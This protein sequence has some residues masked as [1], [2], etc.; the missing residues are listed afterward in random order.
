M[1]HH[2]FPKLY[3][4]S[5][6][7]LSEPEKMLF[8]DVLARKHHGLSP[9]P[10]GYTLEGFIVEECSS[11]LHEFLYELDVPSPSFLDRL[12][13]IVQLGTS[14]LAMHRANRGHY[15][16]KLDN[17][18]ICGLRKTDLWSTANA[19]ILVKLSDFDRSRPLWLPPSA[20]K[21]TDVM[22][23]AYELRA[24][25]VNEDESWTPFGHAADA[26]SFVMTSLQILTLDDRYFDWI[27]ENGYWFTRN[28]NW[29]LKQR[30]FNCMQQHQ[31]VQLL[32]Y[33]GYLESYY[34]QEH[35]RELI[36]LLFE[37]GMNCDATE[38]LTVHRI[39]GL[40]AEYFRR[41]AI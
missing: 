39:M 6:R 3:G 29:N 1:D 26:Y 24:P 36:Q 34:S 15:D 20:R 8:V 37:R 33:H 11:T 5:A 31:N 19:T 41:I 16:I 25:E 17:I 40:F 35:I 38:R 13:I 21:L 2:L 27:A 4:V 22:M 32:K 7:S 9:L 28:P 30:M 10:V 14:L 18:M 12:S 23:G